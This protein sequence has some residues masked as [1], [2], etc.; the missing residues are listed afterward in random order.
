MA[1]IIFHA[2]GAVSFIASQ[3]AAGGAKKGTAARSKKNIMLFSFF[4]LYEYI[5]AAAVKRRT[6][7]RVNSSKILC[8]Q[9]RRMHT[10][11]HLFAAVQERHCINKYTHIINKCRLVSL[12]LY[13]I[14]SSH[15]SHFFVNM[16]MLIL[17][18]GKQCCCTSRSSSSSLQ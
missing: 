9:Q 14:M 5:Y 2:L 15:I 16:Y 18:R 11:N 13:L 7:R 17:P 1:S 10:C 12:I 6:M 4:I 3:R 8:T